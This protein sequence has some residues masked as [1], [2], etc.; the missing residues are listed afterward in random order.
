MMQRA[1]AIGRGPPVSLATRSFFHDAGATMKA[2][3]ALC[4]VLALPA[5]LPTARAG[6]QPA[7]SAVDAMADVYI[8]T[9]ADH[10]AKHGAAFGELLAMRKDKQGESLAVTRLKEFQLADLS[11]RLHEH[12]HVCGGYFAFASR[13]EA[14]AFIADTRGP[15]AGAWPAVSYT[16][17]NRAVVQALLPEAS[18][19]NILAG[20][21]ELSAFRS[22][23]YNSSYGVDASNRIR[24]NWRALAA[25]RSDVTVEQVG[26]GN[27]GP[28]QSVVLTIRGSRFPNEIVVLGGHLDSITSGTGTGDAMIAPGADDDASGIATLTEILRVAMANGYRP[29]RTVQFMAYAAEEV[30]LRGS[31]AIAQSYAQRKE[32]VVGVLQLDMT[33]YRTGPVDMRIVTDFASEPLKGFFAS[34]FDTYL[35]PLGHVRGFDTCGYGCSDHA[36]WHRAGYPAALMFEGG[37][38]DGDYFPYIHTVNDRLQY[39]DPT[40]GTSVP[41]ARFGL[42]FMAETGK[43]SIRNGSIVG[44][45]PRPPLV[46]PPRR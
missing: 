31:N 46:L 42:A 39:Q 3:I 29:Q 12:E 19:D 36:S 37:E 7:S 28:Q 18:A 33:N 11:A 32:R 22:R 13:S 1:S 34:L 4:L 26:C 5:A 40:A 44:D 8:V 15:R 2:L 16:I 27:C 21:T 38:P 45:G 14:E 9:S 10:V 30:G 24:D 23:Y 35:A 20:I 17:D 6:G 41:F 25:G 43:G